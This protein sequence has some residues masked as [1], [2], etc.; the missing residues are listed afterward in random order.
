MLGWKEEGAYNKIMIKEGEENGYYRSWR[1][2]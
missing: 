2:R 1:I